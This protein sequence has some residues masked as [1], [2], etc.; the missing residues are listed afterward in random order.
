MSVG[1]CEI[2]SLLSMG[3]RAT[4]S[5]FWNEF[6]VS[7][8]VVDGH[9]RDLCAHGSEVLRLEGIDRGGVDHFRISR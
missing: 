2:V 4:D 9:R 6:L 5:D 8:Q 7:S 1:D 3:D